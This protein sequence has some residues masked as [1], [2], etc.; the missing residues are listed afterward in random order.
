MPVLMR[1]RGKKVG[2]DSP[3]ELD[4]EFSMKVFS[5][6]GFR[7]P[8]KS[9]GFSAKTLADELGKLAGADLT[10]LTLQSE[11]IFDV[12]S[13]LQNGAP[14]ERSAKEAI[15][16]NREAWQKPKALLTALESARPVL[17]ARAAK[18][19]EP[20]GYTPEEYAEVV[21]DLIERVRIAVNRKAT[22]V[23]LYLNAAL[24]F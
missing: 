9:G 17:D 4:E 8:T 10:P 6:F 14:D 23:C 12:K 16:K 19:V 22:E 1:V 7:M 21:D 11:E 24:L 15:K 3:K 20:F 2:V 18:L 13:Y 5:T